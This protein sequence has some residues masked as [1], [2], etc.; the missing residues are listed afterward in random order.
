MPRSSLYLACLAESCNQDLDLSITATIHLY[1]SLLKSKAIA[2]APG[3]PH[4]VQAT[5]DA[6][7][8]PQSAASA[9]VQA[10]LFKS[11][12]VHTA[13]VDAMNSM[14]GAF[15]IEEVKPSSKKRLRAMDYANEDKKTRHPDVSDGKAK[16]RGKRVEPVIHLDNNS[17]RDDGD[18]WDGLLSAGELQDVSKASEDSDGSVDYTQHASRLAASS[19][20]DSG[21][22]DGDHPGMDEQSIQDMEMSGRS[23]GDDHSEEEIIVSKPRKLAKTKSTTLNS[24]TFLP[25]L[26]MGG[27]W[28][29]SE[30]MSHE[31]GE[32]AA[33]IEIRKNRRGQQARRALWEKKF[34]KNANHVKKQEQSRDHG[35]DPRKGASGGDDRG[36]RGRGRGGKARGQMRDSRPRQGGEDGR[37]KHSSGANSDPM[38][39]RK[40]KLNAEGPLHPSWEAARK[41]KEQKKAVAF[42]GKKVVFD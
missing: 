41:A 25:S 4:H 21:S 29:G 37:P 34:G 38:G 14:R 17:A 39:Q 15:G 12:P 20:E 36:Q 24:T 42:Q 16:P 23:T 13:T 2:S 18:E 3:L 7:R 31:E 35:W 11:Q 19:D 32:N 40:S 6:H 30:P 8:Q 1:K 26:A 10:R 33:K 22:E 5:V 28:S 27:Y 9:N